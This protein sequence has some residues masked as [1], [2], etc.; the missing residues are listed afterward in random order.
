M[1]ALWRCTD[2]VFEVTLVG[3]RWRGREVRGGIRRFA[4]CERPGQCWPSG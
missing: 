2:G 4:R 1:G 3:R